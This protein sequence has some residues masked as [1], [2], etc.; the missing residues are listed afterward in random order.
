[1]ENIENSFQNIVNEINNCKNN[2]EKFKLME[3][4][5]KRAYDLID[6]ISHNSVYSSREE[7][8]NFFKK[9]SKYNV[10]IYVWQENSCRYLVSAF[11]TPL[12]RVDF[13]NRIVN[14][15]D[16]DGYKTRIQEK[17]NSLQ[18]RIDVNNTLIKKYEEMNG[19]NYIR[20]FLHDLRVFEF[21]T[22]SG[23]RR[24]KG[25]LNEKIEGLK[26]ENHL[27]EQAM[28][29]IAINSKT[30]IG[31]ITI[32]QN[33][34]KECFKRENFNYIDD[35]YSE[36]FDVVES[37]RMLRNSKPES[38]ELPEIHFDESWVIENKV[39]IK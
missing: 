4:T 29:D 25:I 18:S 22:P 14:G 19:M 39:T 1:M 11:G 24:A 32:I 27:K 38:E 12:I 15:Y 5:S 2:Q 17:I 35:G 6:S 28:Q 20:C 34:F 9:Y 30:L 33:Y 36:F 31:K 16:I 26:Y 3:E 23:C 21:L 7:L 10:K 37:L 8:I 13:A